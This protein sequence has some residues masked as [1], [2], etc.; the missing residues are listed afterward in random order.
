MSIQDY[1]DKKVAVIGFGITGKACI[2]FFTKAKAKV[3]LFVTDIYQVQ[4]KVSE[5][6]VLKEVQL[7]EFNTTSEFDEFHT[8]VVSPGVDTNHP[9]LKKA[10]ALDIELIS[11]IELF[12]RHNQSP[13]IGI[14]GSNGK[15]SVIDML[16][17]GL[18]SLGIKV[19]IGGNFGVSAVKLLDGQYDII[20]LELSSFQLELTYSLHL[21]IASI[22]NIT[23]DHIDRHGN[24]EAYAE[25]K[26]RIYNNA[27][28][29]IV[30]RDD[31]LTIPVNKSVVY[32]SFGRS[33]VSSELDSFQ[34]EEGIS[35]GGK[36]IFNAYQLNAIS[37]HGRLNLQV[38]LL[39]GFAFLDEEER[40]AFADALLLYK[41]LPHR[42]EL[43][44]TYQNQSNKTVRCIN[45]SKATN[46]GATLAAL[47]TIGDDEHLILI[48]G[49]DS[50]GSD[51]TELAKA[52]ET[53]VD[54]LLCIGQDADKFLALLP[55]AKLFD[56]LDDAV[57]AA[58]REAAGSP[59]DVCILLS[60]ACSSID[61]FENYQHRGECFTQSIKQRSAR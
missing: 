59:S 22:L 61:M 48:A 60:P 16:Y 12:A 54:S 57:E 3:C 38:V 6:S 55:N 53:K 5:Y 23:E 26:Q 24:L 58:I 17:Q 35:V 29:I 43:V 20:L 41:G 40:T 51:L 13:V 25:V 42:F 27:D 56:Q 4:L 37:D 46:P 18:S 50:K 45:D 31:P 28:K 39:C 19:G 7:Q 2:D 36:L 52:I 44:K 9:A 8:V 10:M 14:T 33:E 1:A 49:G 30:N 32:A 15:S 21:Q 47:E 34:D 11:D